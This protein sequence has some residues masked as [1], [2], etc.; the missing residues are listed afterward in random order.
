MH[1]EN[2]LF[3]LMTLK[4]LTLGYMF[5]NKSTIIMHILFQL[6]SFSNIQPYPRMIYSRLGTAT[7][8]ARG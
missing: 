7:S 1:S 3:W 8:E 6:E 5:V 2:H 4:T